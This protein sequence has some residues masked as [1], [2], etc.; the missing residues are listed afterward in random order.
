MKIIERDV[1]RDTKTERHRAI[2]TKK[3]RDRDK[4]IDKE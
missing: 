3:D 4:Y 2:E 1:L